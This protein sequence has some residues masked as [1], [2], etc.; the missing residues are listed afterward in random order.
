M[1]LSSLRAH[2]FLYQKL[3]PILWCNLGAKAVLLHTQ[4]EHVR[5]HMCI[6]HTYHDVGI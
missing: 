6:S 1:D 2:V 4:E 5:A 3:K